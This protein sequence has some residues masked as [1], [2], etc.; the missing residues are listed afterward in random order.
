MDK[1]M[2]SINTRIKYILNNSD[3]EF[4]KHRCEIINTKLDELKERKYK[5]KETVYFI[6]NNIINV[7]IAKMKGVSEQTNMVYK[8]MDELA[9]FIEDLKTVY[10]DK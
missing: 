4:I 10:F 5:D 6:C 1:L 3:N 9:G 7:D 8:K 2:N